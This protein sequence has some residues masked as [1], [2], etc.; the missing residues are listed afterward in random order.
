MLTYFNRSAVSDND[1]VIIIYTS[2]MIIYSYQTKGNSTPGRELDPMI[3]F[4]VFSE[5]AYNIVEGLL[6]LSIERFTKNVKPF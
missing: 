5:S 6:T 3:N 4:D 2:I 1:V